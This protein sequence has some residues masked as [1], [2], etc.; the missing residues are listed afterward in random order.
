MLEKFKCFKIAFYCATGFRGKNLK[1]RG[2]IQGSGL[3]Q[4]KGKEVCD[5]RSSQDR[6]FDDLFLS[7]LEKKINVEVS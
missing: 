5:D 7:A 1:G 3:L 4:R 6:P 2:V